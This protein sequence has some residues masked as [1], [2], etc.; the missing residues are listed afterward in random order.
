MKKILEFENIIVVSPVYWYAVSPPVKVFLDRVSDFLEI[1]ELLDAGR[2]LRGK[3]GYIVCTSVYE[4]APG[5]FVNAL[6]DTFKYLGMRFG[7]MAHA[8]CR[9]GYSRILHEPEVQEF[10]RLVRAPRDAGA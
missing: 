1:P 7:G 10:A 9:E 2:H 6:T 5:P 8:N 4:H 3:S